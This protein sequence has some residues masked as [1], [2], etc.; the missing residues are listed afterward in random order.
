MHE[1][2][3]DWER[4]LTNL[5]DELSELQDELLEILRAKQVS[6]TAGDLAAMQRLQA[7]ETELAGRL[8]QCHDRRTGLLAQAKTEGL[9]G[10]SI[11]HLASAVTGSSRSEL[12][13]RVNQAS[14]RMRLLQHHSLANWVLAQRTLLHLSQLLEIIATGGR[15]RPTYGADHTARGRGALVDRQA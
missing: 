9:P 4:E 7:R 5:L 14:T 3:S 10:E 13:R 15:Q 6:M 2:T 8:Q 1:V 11:T 12:R